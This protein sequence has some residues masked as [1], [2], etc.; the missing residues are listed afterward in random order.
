MDAAS[1]ARMHARGAM[2]W[3]FDRKPLIVF[4]ETTK[5]CDLVCK[6][7]RANAIKNPLPGEL[8]TREGERLIDEVAS[9]GK[10]S[11]ILVFTGGDPLKRGDIWHLLEYAV[12]QGVRAAVA[13]S[14]TPLLTREAVER[15][16]RIGVSGVS[17]SLDSPFEEVH[18]SIRGIPGTWRRTLEAL[19]WFKDA[20]INVQVNTVVMRSTVDGLADMVKLL[21]DLDVRVWEVFYL[22]PVGRAGF[23]EDLTPQEW[24][25]VTHFLYEASKYG[26]RVRTTE[27][28]MFRRV[29]IA[30]TLAEKL[31]RPDLFTRGLG[32]LYERLTARLRE[33]LGEPRGPALAHTTGT[34]DGRGIVFV[35]YKGDV[36]PSGFFPVPAGNIR[37]KSLREIYTESPLFKK[38]RRSE[39]LEGRCGRCEFRH[40]CGG[41]RA[42]AFAYHGRVMAEDPQCPY[43]PGSYRRILEEG[44]LD[45]RLLD[46]ALEWR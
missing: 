7:C 18:D 22:V 40:I 45:P 44:G 12:S 15:M 17:I 27:G 3:P 14:V 13:P 42:K 34:R 26:L 21:L 16:A 43:E 28:P 29:T 37:V 24:E 6:H 39:G 10:P 2:S 36:Y 46:E 19:K 11:P 31:G 5:A 41:S 33:L 20:G 1:A 4:W 32:G 30:R 9:F 8:S 35:N 25:D 23:E 38:L